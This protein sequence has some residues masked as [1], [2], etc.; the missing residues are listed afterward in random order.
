MSAHKPFKWCKVELGVRSLQSQILTWV[1]FLKRR[2]PEIFA[3]VY[4]LAGNGARV[5]GV[6]EGAR[7]GE[8]GG[9]GRDGVV[10][11]GGARRQALYRLVGQ[12]VQHLEPAKSIQI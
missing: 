5:D 7:I 10:V 8:G 11:G 3:R 2:S 4:K 12:R 9:G 1:T 6:E